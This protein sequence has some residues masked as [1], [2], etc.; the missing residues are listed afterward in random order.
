MVKVEAC[1]YSMREGNRAQGDLRWPSRLSGFAN[2]ASGIDSRSRKSLA[3]SGSRRRCCRASSAESDGCARWIESG[4]RACSVRVWESCSRWS[5]GDRRLGAWP[6]A[7]RGAG[8][9]ARRDVRAR[10]GR[11]RCGA[12]GECS[13]AGGQ[14]RREPQGA[15]GGPVNSLTHSHECLN[16][17]AC[18]SSTCRRGW[19]CDSQWCAGQHR[20]H[21]SIECQTAQAV[22]PIA[23]NPPERWQ[24]PPWPPVVLP[25][26]RRARA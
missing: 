13:S 21:S 7:P 9:L 20:R 3:C 18:P 26:M 14:R 12:G 19:I 11:A 15:R 4:S 22:K 8:W 17:P 5:Y 2:G 1:L 10:D 16:G 23:T 6:A 25:V 24:T